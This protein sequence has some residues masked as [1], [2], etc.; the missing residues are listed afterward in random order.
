MAN[1]RKI[2]NTI[3]IDEAGIDL[4]QVNQENCTPQQFDYFIMNAPIGSVI[5]F[6]DTLY[7]KGRS[8]YT[9]G[10]YD[11]EIWEVVD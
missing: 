11:V 3:T 4:I 10:S 1:T 5:R 6:Y 9:D 2:H 8:D 7:F